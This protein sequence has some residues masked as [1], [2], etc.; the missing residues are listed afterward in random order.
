MAL[1]FG[2][3]VVVLGTSLVRPGLREFGLV[4]W[5]WAST[6]HGPSLRVS[7]QGVGEQCLAAGRFPECPKLGMFPRVL[8]VLHRDYS[9]PYYNPYQGL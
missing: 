3:G 2:S 8:T 4:S 7:C 5:L 6:T 1:G 9:T